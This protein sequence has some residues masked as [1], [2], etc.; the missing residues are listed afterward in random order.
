MDDCTHILAI[1]TIDSTQICDLRRFLR[2][3][4][5]DLELYITIFGN[6]QKAVDKAGERC[7][8]IISNRLKLTLERTFLVPL[9]TQENQEK[10]MME[11]A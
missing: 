10:R 1:L 8:T 5:S 4:I 3:N 9:L 2:R 7:F 6:L 11:N